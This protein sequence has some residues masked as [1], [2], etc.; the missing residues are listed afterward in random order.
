[1]LQLKNFWILKE[2]ILK[3]A[4]TPSGILY[5]GPYFL[6]SLTSK[7]VIEYEK[8]PNYWDKDNVKIDNIKLTFYDGSD[9]ESLIRSFTQG[10]YT[11]ARLFP[12]KFKF[13]VN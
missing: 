6:K 10:A 11:T 2:R 9:Q 1:M 7:S 5:N 13:W 4:P 12:N 3:G 8:N